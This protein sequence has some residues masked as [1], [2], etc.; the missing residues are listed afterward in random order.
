MLS[1]AT[2]SKLHLDQILNSHS[3]KTVGSAQYNIKILFGQNG[4]PKS[5]LVGQLIG[6]LKIDYR[7]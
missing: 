3:L 6:H 2:I 4:Q 1:S 7:H 5:F